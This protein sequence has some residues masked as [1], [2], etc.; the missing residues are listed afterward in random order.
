MENIGKKVRENPCNVHY[1][2]CLLRSQISLFSKP[3]LTRLLVHNHLIHTFPPATPLPSRLFAT[4]SLFRNL[5]LCTALMEST[6][7]SLKWECYSSETG[8]KQELCRYLNILWLFLL[9]TWWDWNCLGGRS[10][11]KFGSMYLNRKAWSSAVCLLSPQALIWMGEISR[12]QW[13]KGLGCSFWN[14]TAGDTCV[15]PICLL[16]HSRQWQNREP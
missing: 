11:S 6:S 3:D 15:D 12:L 10:I 13:N 2:W 7:R 8:I 4:E 5:L 14:Y 1:S 16:P 9:I